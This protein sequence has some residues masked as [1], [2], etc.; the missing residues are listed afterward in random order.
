MD[1]Q[2]TI[3]AARSQA[4]AHVERAGLLV[5]EGVPPEK[6][7]NDARRRPSLRARRLWCPRRSRQ[8]NPPAISS[9]CP[10][11]WSSPAA[12]RWR[13][14]SALQTRMIGVT[15]PHGDCD[16]QPHVASRAGVGS[17]SCTPQTARQVPRQLRLQLLRSGDLRLPPRPTWSRSRRCTATATSSRMQQA[18]PG[19]AL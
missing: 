5:I 18:A 17:V 11:A 1:L 8:E 14:A 9:S 4:L 10:S 7:V 13:P 3:W 12:P 6:V 2:D 15:V 19:W 16:K